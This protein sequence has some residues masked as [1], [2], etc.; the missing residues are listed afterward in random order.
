MDYISHDN[1]TNDSLHAVQVLKCWTGGCMISIKFVTQVAEMSLFYMGLIASP[2]SWLKLLCF[3]FLMCRASLSLLRCHCCSLSI[4][5]LLLQSILWASSMACRAPPLVWRRVADPR[6]RQTTPP[7]PPLL[8]T[9]LCRS[10]PP[11]MQTF[12][13]LVDDMMWVCPSIHYPTNTADNLFGDLHWKDTALKSKIKK[14]LPHS[15]PSINHIR[16]T[17]LCYYINWKPLWHT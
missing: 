7:F 13:W 9:S 11:S 10:A 16:G 15:T 1:E 4:T 3:F 14:K 5:V 8:G 12:T 17:W 2:W 6:V